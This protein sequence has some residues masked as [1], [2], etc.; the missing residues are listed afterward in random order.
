MGLPA[1][2]KTTITERFLKQYAPDRKTVKV[3]LKDPSSSKAHGPTLYLER[4][5]D[6]NFDV[7]GKYQEEGVKY[8]G[9]DC[10]A[11]TACLPAYE[12]FDDLDHDVFFEGSKF[13]MG[14]LL[15]NIMSNPNNELKIIYLN[16]DEDIVNDRRSKRTD[17][18]GMVP[19]SRVNGKWVHRPDLCRKGPQ[20]DKFARSQKTKC[21]NIFNSPD[22]SHICVKMQ[23]NVEED[24]D[25]IVAYM[26][27]Y[28][29]KV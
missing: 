11:N 1:S 28:Y 8:K 3:V 12:Y 19:K 5:E 21:D 23:S 14:K 18:I 26:N 29:G 2:G 9:T 16:S 24:I 22:F 4:S 17:T 20:T 15:R 25:K 27:T 6:P 10:L 7:L 13:S